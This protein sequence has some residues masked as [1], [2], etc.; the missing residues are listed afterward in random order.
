[1]VA[2]CAIIPCNSLRGRIVNNAGTKNYYRNGSRKSIKYYFQLW[3]AN[4]DLLSLHCH[5]T[6]LG[7]Y[8]IIK[9]I[10]NSSFCEHFNVHPQHSVINFYHTLYPFN[11][12]KASNLK[13]RQP[14]PASGSAV[15]LLS[16]CAT[17]IFSEGI[18]E[19][20]CLLCSCGVYFVMHIFVLYVRQLLLFR[21]N[22][23]PSF[24]LF[25]WWAEFSWW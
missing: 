5:K 17:N 7:V 15:I 22:V 6:Y 20:K 14:Y 21:S 11:S 12:Q 24:L 9:Y 19:L 8:W 3:N 25:L 13:F 16:P 1:M 18:S 23:L 10:E 2:A 4:S